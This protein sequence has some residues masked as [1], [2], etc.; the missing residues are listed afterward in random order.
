[1]APAQEE[2]V[3]SGGVSAST[4]IDAPGNPDSTRASAVVRPDTPAPMMSTSV[5]ELA[6]SKSNRDVSLSE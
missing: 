6:I 5:L 2:V 4:R 1:M 3:S